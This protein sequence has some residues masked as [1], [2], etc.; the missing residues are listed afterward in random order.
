M[1]FFTRHLRESEENYFEHFLVT[2]STAFWLIGTGLILLCHAV[3]PFLFVSKAGNNVRKINQV[4]QK[5]VEFFS[6]KK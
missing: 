5:R 3:L 1:N 2:F 6:K 4:M